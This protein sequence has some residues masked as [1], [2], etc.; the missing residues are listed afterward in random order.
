MVNFIIACHQLRYE[1]IYETFLGTV[2]KN[3][4]D[5]KTCYRRCLEYKIIKWMISGTLTYLGVP[6]QNVVK[7]SNV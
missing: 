2:Y 4:E 3:K 5:T 6:L 1:N 7:M